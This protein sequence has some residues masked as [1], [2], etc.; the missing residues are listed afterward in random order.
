[1]VRCLVSRLG[2]TEF[3]TEGLISAN[4]RLAKKYQLIENMQ[5]QGAAAANIWLENSDAPALL[6]SLVEKGK[7]LSLS[8]LAAEGMK[9]VESSL[10]SKSADV[11]KNLANS[12]LGKLLF[13]LVMPAVIA[14]INLWFFGH[15]DF[16]LHIRQLAQEGLTA[17]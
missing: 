13:W 10:R 12:W 11:T 17:K 9:E 14:V 6:E 2:M 4:E 7:L 3:N 5:Q 1:M 15:T 8:D 16:L